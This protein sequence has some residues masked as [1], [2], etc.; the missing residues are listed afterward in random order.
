MQTLSIKQKIMVL[1]TIPVILLTLILT[2]QSIR[3]A[4]AIAQMSLQ[5]LEASL[6]AERRSQLDAFVELAISATASASTDDARK[7]ILRQL[8]YEQGNNYFFVY[9]TAGVQV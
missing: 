6:F 7:Q 5:Q 1:A 4:N 9:N 3:Q 2:W 8:R